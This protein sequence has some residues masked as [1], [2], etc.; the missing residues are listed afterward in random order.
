MA[1]WCQRV[2]AVGRWVSLAVIGLGLAVS[3][4]A[5]AQIN[6]PALT[7]Q[8]QVQPQG[9][10][11]F[12][13]A[14]F[15][16]WVP[17]IKGPLRGVIIRQHGCGRKGLDHADDVQWQALALK[18]HCAL[19]GSHF[20]PT[21]Q[22]AD[23]FEPQGG[24]ERAL[25]VALETFAE[26]TKRPELAKVPWAIW[27]HSGGAL[28][29][30]HLLNRRPQRVA[31]VWARSQALVEMQPAAR[32]VPVMLNYG[33][34]E[35]VGKFEAVHRNSL[36]SFNKHR[37][38]GALWAL[39]VDPKSSHDCRE[40]RRLAVPWF[41]AVLTLRLPERAGEADLRPLAGAE[42]WL[43]NPGTLAIAS[44]A[45][46]VGDKL[47]ACWLPNEAVARQWQEY[48]KTGTVADPTRPPAPTQVR[49]LFKDGV[50][51]LSWAATA[52]L[53]SGTR[54]F[55]IYRDGEKIGSLGGAVGRANKNG[56]YQTHNYG[57]EPEPRPA[58]LRFTDPHGQLRSRYEVTQENH[59][60]LE[61]P[62]SPPVV[63]EDCKDC[64]Q[65]NNRDGQRSTGW[66]PVRPGNLASISRKNA[67]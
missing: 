7:L 53:E 49:A 39:A 2:G 52:D 19:L 18:H 33:V 4:A 56:D 6:G 42:G 40:S 16:L 67:P 50:V 37:P 26:Q 44:A 1:G 3:A 64:R 65:C 12:H 21:N 31:A 55:H 34:G 17:E 43:G 29:A 36:A 5:V 63:P 38:A 47:Q 66:G 57:D 41:D 61:S 22:C 20:V 15:R 30:M 48:C 23:W 13:S 25:L 10:D 9:N 45:E 27:G 35:Q 24:S 51:T 8:L 46:Y 32:A 28:W 54:R 60:G 11:K 58:P 14:E 62:P 59:A